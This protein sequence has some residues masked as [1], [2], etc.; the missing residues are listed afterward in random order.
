MGHDDVFQRVNRR[1]AHLCPL[2]RSQTLD[3]LEEDLPDF[4]EVYGGGL[5]LNDGVC[6]AACRLCRSTALSDLF[7]C[8][9]GH[10]LEHANRDQVVQRVKSATR[11]DIKILSGEQEAELTHV[12]Q[13]LIKNKQR[14]CN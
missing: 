4:L 6:H 9:V 13:T 7:R 10:V 8:V 14:I 11:I 2:V 12:I 1:F 5:L 3:P